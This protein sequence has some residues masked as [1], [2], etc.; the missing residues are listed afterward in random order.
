M[1]YNI[2][3]SKTGSGSYVDTLGITF[4][5]N[6]TTGNTILVAVGTEG[7][8]FVYDLSDSQSN[9]YTEVL[10]DEGSDGRV[11]LWVAENITGGANTV[12]IDLRADNGSGPPPDNIW[13]PIAAIVVEVSGLATSSEDVSTSADDTTNYPTSMSTG[14]TSTPSQD[15]N[16]VVALPGLK[17]TDASFSAS[18]TGFTTLVSVSS[19][20]NAHTAFLHKRITSAAAQSATISWSGNLNGAVGIAVFKEDAG[21]SP[22]AARKIQTIVT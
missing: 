12:T 15:D 14:S 21:G 7:D 10:S 17:G 6:V 22:P 11:E 9:T 18:A 2:E 20:S 4:D 16:L 1:A 5:S 8:G 13:N 19:S 3:Q